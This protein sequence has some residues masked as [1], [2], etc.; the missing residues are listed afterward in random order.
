MSFLCK[1][2][3]HRWSKPKSFSIFSSNVIDYS[4]YCLKCKKTKRWNK[5]KRQDLD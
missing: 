1:I 2:G 4:R 5:I 3:I